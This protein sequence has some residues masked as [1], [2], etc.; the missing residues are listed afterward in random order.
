[1]FLAAIDFVQAGIGKSLSVLRFSPPKSLTEGF[2]GALPALNDFLAP[3]ADVVP[4]LPPHDGV[5]A[6]AGPV[7]A[8][9]FG[10]P[11]GWTHYGTGWTYNDSVGFIRQNLALWDQW[12]N[13]TAVSQTPRF[14]RRL[15]SPT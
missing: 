3:S 9:L 7:G 10:I 6:V 14:I 8:W 13:A 4:Y 15:F 5:N 1:M 12:P 11:I 2:T